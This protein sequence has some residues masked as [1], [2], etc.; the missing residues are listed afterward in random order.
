MAVIS[1]AV[2]SDWRPPIHELAAACDLPDGTVHTILTEDLDLV[3]KLACWVP[4]LLSRA[5]TQ[6][7]AGC[8]GDSSAWFVS[9]HGQHCDDG[10]L[11]HTKP[12]IVHAVDEEGSA[13]PNKSQSPCD[14]HT[15]YTTGKSVNAE[16]VEKAVV[17]YLK[18]F[19]IMFS[20][21]WLCTGTTPKSLPLLSQGLPG[22]FLAVKGIKDNLSCSLF[23]RSRPSKPFSL[24]ESEVWAAGLSQPQDSFKTS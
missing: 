8:S 1:A 21:H 18:D 3:K 20:Q 6:E 10:L 7:W 14:I 9:S 22:S 11:P 13:R 16:Y 12:K 5:Q 24:W 19:S 23:T 15:N 4:I 17:R 2:E